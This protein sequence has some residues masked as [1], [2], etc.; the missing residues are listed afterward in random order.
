VAFGDGSWDFFP[1]YGRFAGAVCGYME[2]G[3]DD[4]HGMHRNWVK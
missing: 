1:Y 2:K 3:S 4:L